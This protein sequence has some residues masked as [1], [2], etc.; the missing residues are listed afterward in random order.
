[1]WKLRNITALLTVLLKNIQTFLSKQVG[2]GATGIQWIEVRDTAQH[3]KERF[4]ILYNF[5]AAK[6]PD[7][8]F[9]RLGLQ[10]HFTCHQRI[11]GTVLIY[12][13]FSRETQLLNKSRENYS[14]CFCSF[15]RSCSPFWKTKPPIALKLMALGS[16]IY[17]P[18]S[19]CA[20]V[21]SSWWLYVCMYK[22]T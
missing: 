15:I 21:V 2:G 8:S 19:V 14:L 17:T 9:L 12:T 11:F 4:C 3:N 13:E 5:H 22:Y 16:A 6:K 7:F 1:M 10:L 20:C 18:I